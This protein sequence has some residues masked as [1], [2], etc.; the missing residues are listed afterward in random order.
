MKSSCP[1]CGEELVFRW[2]PDEIPY[3]GEIMHISATCKCGFKHADTLILGVQEPVRYELIVSS[4]EDLDTRVI[5]STSGTIRIPEL[6]ID[7]EPGP[8]S[9]SFVTNIEGVLERIKDIV[10]MTRKWTED[11]VKLKRIDE[12]LGTIEGAKSGDAQLTIIIEDPLGNSAILSERATHRSLTKE[13]ISKLK[14]GMVVLDVSKK[15]P[16]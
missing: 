2:R 6:G 8:A 10:K 12:V 9:E 13:E 16:T 4:S 1:M 11:D 3:F 7:V 5:R 14:T 15:G